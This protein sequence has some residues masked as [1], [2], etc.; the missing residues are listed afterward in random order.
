M[1]KCH[2]QHIHVVEEY[3]F[4]MFNLRMENKFLNK[5]REVLITKFTLP[6]QMALSL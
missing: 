1:K 6:V 2:N 3:Y 4:V 5:T